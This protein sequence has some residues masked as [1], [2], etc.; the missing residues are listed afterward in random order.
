MERALRIREDSLG[1]THPTVAPLLDCLARQSFTRLDF[2]RAAQLL[3]R[4]MVVR[5]RFVGP[6]HPD[7]AETV[8]N[9]GRA[10]HNLGDFL[11]AAKQ[12]ERAIVIQTEVFGVWS[13][14]VI[15]STLALALSYEELGE[16]GKADP[17]RDRADLLCQQK[18]MEDLQ[19]IA[20]AL[21][22]YAVDHRSYPATSDIKTLK[23]RLH[24]VY[25][26]SMP[27]RDGWGNPYVVESSATS[28]TL[29]SL[30]KDGRPNSHPGGQTSG[31]TPDIIFCDGSFT[32][33]PQDL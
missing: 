20:N 8:F 6:S 30:A 24:P 13:Q 9:L 23:E 12:F 4:S 29:K 2:D 26:R 33:W 19:T 16:P 11:Q 5:E 22:E 7:V 21:F 32:Q 25:M 18:A 28:F 3:Q 17:L 15:D 14:P 1:W 27:V 10:Q 31:F